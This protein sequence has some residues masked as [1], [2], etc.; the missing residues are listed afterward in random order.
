[1]NILIATPRPEAWQAFAT[2][3]EAEGM[4]T[5]FLASGG[6]ILLAATAQTSPAL[7]IFDQGLPDGEPLEL[8]RKLLH[9]NA[10]VNIAVVDTRDEETFHDASEGLGVMAQLS[11]APTAEDGEAIC[12]RLRRILGLTLQAS[13]K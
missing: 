7:A 5:E 3:L 11:P 6:S 13:I 10:M 8:A 12:Q 4:I 2:R 1:M 9:V